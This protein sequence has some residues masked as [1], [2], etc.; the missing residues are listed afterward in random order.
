MIYAAFFTPKR[1]SKKL[2][3]KNNKTIVDRKFLL[4][5]H[6]ILHLTS[7]TLFLT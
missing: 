5:L 4:Y 6:P 1:Q 2:C 7:A 3:E